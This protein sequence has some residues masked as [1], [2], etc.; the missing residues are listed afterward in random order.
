[1][2]RRASRRS[3]RVA[4]TARVAAATSAAPVASHAER[5]EFPDST[6]TV[7]ALR[8]RARE[9]G[10]PGYSRLSKEQLIE[11]VNS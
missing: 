3:A 6:W 4:E 2:R 11:L 8:A 1:M 10:L 7:V 9:R 5:T